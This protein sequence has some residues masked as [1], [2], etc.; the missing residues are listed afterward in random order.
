M[1]TFASSE[2]KGHTGYLIFAKKMSGRKMNTR[3]KTAEVK[4]EVKREEEDQEI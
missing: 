3:N 2:M 1:H 4:G